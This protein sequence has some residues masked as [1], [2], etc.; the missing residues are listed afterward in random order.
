M[1]DPFYKT[2]N[3][4]IIPS[5]PVWISPWELLNGDIANL[6]GDPQELLMILESYIRDFKNKDIEAMESSSANYLDKI[7][8]MGDIDIQNIKRETTY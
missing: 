6:P 3:L 8:M 5:T 1:G 7:S 4:K 2:Y